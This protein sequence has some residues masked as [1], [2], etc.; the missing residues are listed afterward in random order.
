MGTR[1]CTVTQKYYRP[2]FPNNM[3]DKEREFISNLTEMFRYL[4]KRQRELEENNKWLATW[5]AGREKELSENYRNM[6]D[7][8]LKRFV[9]EPDD[10]L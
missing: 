8:L 5:Y 9:N 7:R 2:C 4:A 6:T 1:N 3:T 10:N